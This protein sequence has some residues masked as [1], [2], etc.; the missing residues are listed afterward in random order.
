MPEFYRNL[1]KSLSTPSSPV[2][3]HY[4]SNSI[5]QL[6]PVMQ[7]FTDEHYIHGSLHLRNVDSDGDKVNAEDNNNSHKISTVKRLLSTFPKRKFILVGDSGKILF[8][9]FNLVGTIR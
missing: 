8:T 4:V 6:A 2:A 5:I 3:Y 1:S 9:S 7:G